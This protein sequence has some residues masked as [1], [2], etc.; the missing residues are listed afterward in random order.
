VRTQEGLDSH[1]GSFQVEYDSDKCAICL[2][3]IPLEETGLI[4][5]CGHT[6]W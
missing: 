1:V 5:G 6:Y 4:K 2:E 3:T